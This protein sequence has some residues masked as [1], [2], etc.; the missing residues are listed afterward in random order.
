MRHSH[1]IIF[2]K[3]GLEKLKETKH[4]QRPPNECEWSDLMK[5]VD[6]CL[7]ILKKPAETEKPAET[8]KP[9][10]TEKAG[11][12]EKPAETEKAGEIQKPESVDALSAGGAA[13]SPTPEETSPTAASSPKK[14]LKSHVMLSYNME[15]KPLVRKLNAQLKTAGFTT[16]IEDD[17]ES[18]S[19]IDALEGAVSN[20][21]VVLV[22]YSAGYQ[23]SANCRSEAE[24]TFRSKAMLFVRVE[25]D[26]RADGWLKFIMGQAIYYDLVSDPSI[27]EQLIRHIRQLYDGKDTADGS[28]AL[29]RGEYSDSRRAVLSRNGH[30]LETAGSSAA[31][32]P[33]KELECSSWTVEQVQNWV[34][35]KGLKFLLES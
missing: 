15:S 25:R 32:T 30:P 12:T 2:L 17:I 5:A 33:Q 9:A 1:F 19:L 18:G 24:Y 3:T 16:W 34:Q 31:A 21:A 20:S 22:C 23:R 26:Y 29:A 13:S 14:P 35:E 28:E 6:F 8:K 27:I 7:H 11:E 10:E 4:I